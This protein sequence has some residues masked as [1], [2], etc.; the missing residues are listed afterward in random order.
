M[1][2]FLFAASHGHSHVLELLASEPG[3]DLNQ[4]DDEGRTGLHLAA[5]SKKW[6]AVDALIKLGADLTVR[7]ANGDTAEDA[8]MK[9][10]HEILA[11]LI[12]LTLEEQEDES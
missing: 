6:A 12:K 2:P 1:T 9:N 7:D 10:G 4:A 3:I 5:A 11:L 8:A